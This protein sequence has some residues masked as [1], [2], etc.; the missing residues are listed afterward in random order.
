MP[1]QLLQIHT[2]IKD[3]SDSRSGNAQRQ[4]LPRTLMPAAAKAE[5]APVRT[6]QQKPLG[7]CISQR[8]AVGRGQQHQNHL[9]SLEP[10][11]IDLASLCDKAPSVLYRWIKSLNLGQQ[12]VH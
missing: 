3:F 5:T 10:H 11:A 2:L 1:R 6:I 4:C 8:I 7:L 12:C 9:A